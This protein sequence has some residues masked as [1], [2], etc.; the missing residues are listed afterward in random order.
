MMSCSSV[1]NEFVWKGG[2]GSG[3]NDVC[4]HSQTKM[5]FFGG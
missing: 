1:D 5:M 2:G 3:G 4:G